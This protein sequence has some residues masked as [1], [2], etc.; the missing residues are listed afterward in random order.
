MS[1]FFTMVWPNQKMNWPKILQLA[2]SH[3]GSN[4]K[5]F[6]IDIRDGCFSDAFGDP[7]I[8]DILGRWYL[9]YVFTDI[10]AD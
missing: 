9:N 10:W 3:G 8:L 5:S 6:C 2:I 4:M 7:N 1:G